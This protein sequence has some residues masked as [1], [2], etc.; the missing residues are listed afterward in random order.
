MQAQGRS[1]LLA[2]HID[3]KW[4]AVPGS[5]SGVVPLLSNLLPL[6]LTHMRVPRLVSASAGTPEKSLQAFVRPPKT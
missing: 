2:L 4:R 5:S 3:N 1:L 6:F